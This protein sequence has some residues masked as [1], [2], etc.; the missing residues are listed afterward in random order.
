MH[1]A[2]RLYPYNNPCLPLG[3]PSLGEGLRVGF[4]WGGTKG[5]FPKPSALQQQAPCPLH[6]LRTSQSS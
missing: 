2:S 4:P 6:C 5:G 3:F 1:N